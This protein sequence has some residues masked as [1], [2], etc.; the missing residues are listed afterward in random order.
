MRVGFAE[1]FNTGLR[2]TGT[3]TTYIFARI[4]FKIGPHT[5]FFSVKTVKLVIVLVP[6]NFKLDQFFSEIHV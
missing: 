1:F 6:I 3:G 4:S 2:K 5:G